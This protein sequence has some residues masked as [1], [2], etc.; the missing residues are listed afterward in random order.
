LG[1]SASR[2]RSSSDSAADHCAPSVTPL[3]AEVSM[4]G[5]RIRT[6]ISPAGTGSL[7]CSSASTS[8]AVG[9]VGELAPETSGTST[10]RS[11]PL[12]ATSGAASAVAVGAAASPTSMR[13][14]SP[15]CTQ[16]A[17]SSALKVVASS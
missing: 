2:R 9:S 17:G 15:G 6:L 7:R 12:A 11:P 3:V 14:R 10:T 4:Y 5:A 13:T 8:A 16:A 1:A